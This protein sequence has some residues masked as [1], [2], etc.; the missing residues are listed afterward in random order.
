MTARPPLRERAIYFF[1]PRRCGLCGAVIASE[2][3]LCNACSASLPCILPPCCGYC[4]ASRADCDCE[5]H[6]P[7][8][9]TLCAPFYYDGAAREGIAQLKFRDKPRRA[10]YLGGQMAQVLRREFPTLPFDLLCCVPLSHARLR[11]RRY[12]QSAL[13]AAQLAKALSLPFNADL[14]Q[15]PLD[16]ASQRSYSQDRRRANV[17]GTIDLCAPESIAGKR[18]L[19]CDDVVTTGATLNECA[20]ILLLYDAKEVCCVCACKTRKESR[21]KAKESDDF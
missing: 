21:K 9:H 15:K 2:R 10:E 11:E 13:L 17:L 12:N 6:V 5:K 4:G 1:F 8:Y 3:E 20:K 14:L 16:I 18:I 7:F 19:L